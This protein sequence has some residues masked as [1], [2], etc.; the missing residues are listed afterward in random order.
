MKSNLKSTAP[1][2][3]ERGYL[4]WL[5]CFWAVASKA[6]G[7]DPPNDQAHPQ[8]VAAVVERNQRNRNEK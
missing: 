5:S 7:I 1:D 4:S 8:P 3:A 6:V 2:I